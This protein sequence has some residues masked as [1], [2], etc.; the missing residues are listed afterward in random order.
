M[1]MSARSFLIL[2]GALAFGTASMLGAQEWLL[3][4]NI[5]S[6]E[7]LPVQGESAPLEPKLSN[8]SV[9]VRMALFGAC[10]PD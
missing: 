5:G 9:V 10:E 4:T 8:I 2:A 3:A 6:H 1:K 7:G